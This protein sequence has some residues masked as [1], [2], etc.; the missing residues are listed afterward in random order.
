MKVG[1]TTASAYIP[2]Y[3]LNRDVIAKA[4][5]RS[6]I[7]G[8]RSVANTDEDSLTMA[9]ETAMSCCR[10]VKRDTIDGLYFASTTAPYNEKSISSTIAVVC[11]LKENIITSDFSNSTRAGTSALLAACNA[12][13]AGSAKNIL[14]TAADC[15]NGYPKS[16]QEQLFGDGAAAVLVGK[17][18]VV[19]ELVETHSQNIEITDIWRNLNDK[20]VNY[21]ESRFINE[22]GY[23]YAMTKAV[24]SLL[25]KT[26]IK[27]TQ[28]SKVIFSTNGLKDGNKLAQKMGFAPEQLQESYMQQVGNCGTAQPLF[29]LTAALEEAKAGDLILMA[30]YGNGADTFLFKVTENVEVFQ[31]G[32][33]LKK[34]IAIKRYLESYTKYLSFRN[35]LEFQPGEPFRTFPSNAATWR[36]QKGIFKLY[37]SKCKECGTGIFPINRVCPNCRS[38]DKFKE[39]RLSDRHPKVFTYSIDYLAGRGDDP[40]VVQTVAD[41]EEGIRYYLLMTDFNKE[42]IKIGMEVEFTF[43]K[44]YEGGNY[45]NYYW[46]CRP[47]RKV[48]E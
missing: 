25:G 22:K 30:A 3:R 48:G 4:W 1:I 8:E 28:I 21:G 41:D 37:G 42:E 31:I 32:R 46:K 33:C 9:V 2:Y 17:D 26:G 27:Q 34:K 38:V 29:M 7:K 15:R 13:S 5:E 35:L 18:N 19:A 45:I 6:A 10:M 43:R 23:I 44:I 36:E 14:I 11:D 20:Y 47:V 40:L 16:D 24:Q 39:I 12:V